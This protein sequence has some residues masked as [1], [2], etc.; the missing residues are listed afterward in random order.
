M[1][2]VSIRHRVGRIW[3]QGLPSE[4]HIRVFTYRAL[5]GLVRLH[6]FNIIETQGL[7]ASDGTD[8]PFPL[9]IRI[10]E[11]A[12]ALVPAFSHTI[13]LVMKKQTHV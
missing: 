8:S 11:R 13:Q 12:I 7:T 3:Y 1:T 4:D 6:D 9:P 2:S 5:R 10:A